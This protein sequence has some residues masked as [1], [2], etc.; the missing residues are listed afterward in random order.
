MRGVR[1]L[2]MAALVVGGST[3]IGAG[4][5]IGQD[6]GGRP[7]QVGSPEGDQDAQ[8]TTLATRL[9]QRLSETRERI[10]RYQQ[11]ERGLIDAIAR[12]EAGESPEAI[13]TTMRERVQQ[14]VREFRERGVTGD[15]AG[16]RAS[17][18]DRA[19]G[20]RGRDARQDASIEGAERFG[21]RSG[22]RGGGE[23][24]PIDPALRE[25]VLASLREHSPAMYE[26][27]R[28][29]GKEQPEQSE[30]VLQR[31][32]P[33]IQQ[34]QGVRQEDPELATL[35]I[36]ELHANLDLMVHSRDLRE[37]MH[38]P[39]RDD[40][41][42]G[43]LR[44]GVRDALRRSF[45]AHLAVKQREVTGLERKLDG[46]REEIRKREELREQFIERQADQIEGGGLPTIPRGGSG[47]RG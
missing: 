40:G 6:A 16:D 7:A 9:R 35:M 14:G 20:A 22:A 8:R 45:D 13:Y 34:I 42:I 43:A 31:L 32:M 2:A 18:E 10:S 1:G 44:A 41:R 39:E 12:L 27:V 5:A 33:R 29:L 37:A 23:R 28:T 38:A 11:H 25:R 47:G 46:L 4:L 21:D 24:A 15:A 17:G 19:D 36:H 26:R 30:R 3:L